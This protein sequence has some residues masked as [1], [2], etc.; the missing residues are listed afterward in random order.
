ML[1][2]TLSTI[3]CEK[4][5]IVK[6][7]SL[8]FGKMTKD[9]KQSELIYILSSLL[10]QDKK[11]LQSFLQKLTSVGLFTNF[12]FNSLSTGFM[13]NVIIPYTPK[14]TIYSPFENLQFVGRGT[15]GRVYHCHHSLDK[16]EYAIKEIPL[17][18]SENV[19]D[20]IQIL[21]ELYHPNIVRYYNSWK[22]NNCLMIQMEFCPSSLR[23]YLQMETRDENI[24]K[25][26][27]LGLVYLHKKQYI[28]FDLKPENILLTE[29]NQVKIADFG[30]SRSVLT[31][32]YK[33]HYYEPSLYLCQNDIEYNTS[34][35]VYS[36]GIVL[37]EFTLPKTI[38]QCETIMNMREQLQTRQWNTN[39][40]K[41]HS[42]LTR[43]LETIQTKRISTEDI[44]ELYF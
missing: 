11:K 6:S 15:F 5:T 44:Y 26:I 42:L 40:P 21:S 41:Y 2:K 37:L 35:D 25:Q 19:L 31:S 24:L 12:S 23:C 27:V 34:I 18:E 7:K 38:T 4:K 28:H 36:F 43:C 30:Y 14:N 13:D 1:K 3:S 8:D 32:I 39:F 22:Q 33:S 10:I 9:M 16:K 17:E 29:Q 20:E